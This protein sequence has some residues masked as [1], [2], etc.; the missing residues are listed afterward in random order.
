MLAG[1]AGAALAHIAAPHIAYF[2]QGGVIDAAH[3][4]EQMANFYG[5]IAAF[6]CT[7][8]VTVAVSLF[9]RPRPLSELKGLVWGLPDPNSPDAAE[10]MHMTTWYRS[11]PVLGAIVLAMA[12]AA[13]LILIYWRATL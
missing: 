4:S 2:H 12:L 5:A 6:I 3:F 10:A 11:P 1:T 8:V 9:T 7:S 13:S